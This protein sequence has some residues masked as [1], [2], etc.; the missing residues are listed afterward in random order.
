MDINFR[1]NF[2]STDPELNSPTKDVCAKCG[3][4]FIRGPRSNV[5]SCN[6]GIHYKY[7]D[8]QEFGSVALCDK[9]AKEELA[10]K[11]VDRIMF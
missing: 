8:P 5:F 7:E 10:A 2:I 9:C 6:P 4:S 1:M 11:H 3:R